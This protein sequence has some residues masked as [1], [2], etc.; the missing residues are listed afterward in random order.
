MD[1]KKRLKRIEGLER[2]KKEHQE[3]VRN[4]EG[5]NGHLIPYWEGEI[6]RID[7]AIR[8]EKRKIEED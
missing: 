8:E 1:K 4:Y 7:T 6:E 2:A 3:K 5:K